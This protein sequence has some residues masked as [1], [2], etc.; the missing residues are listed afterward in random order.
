MQYDGINDIYVKTL[1]SESKRATGCRRSE[2]NSK[3]F[4]SVSDRITIRR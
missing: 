4:S 2:S 1:H 3:W